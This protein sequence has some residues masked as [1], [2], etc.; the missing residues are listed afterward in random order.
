M[1]PVGWGYRKL[2]EL[3][4]SLETHLSPKGVDAM[5]SYVTIGIGFGVGLGINGLCKRFIKYISGTDPGV[6]FFPTFFGVYFLGGL[7]VVRKHTNMKTARMKKLADEVIQESHSLKIQ[8]FKKASG[9]QKM[10]SVQEKGWFDNIH[11]WSFQTTRE[12]ETGKPKTLIIEATNCLAEHLLKI[13][14]LINNRHYLENLRNLSETHDIT[15]I[16]PRTE[17]ELINDLNQIPDDSIDVLW[18]RGHGGPEVISF[19]RE[20]KPSTSDTDL[21]KNLAKKIKQL[22][23]AVFM[24][25][26]NAKGKKNITRLFSTFLKNGKT[27]GSKTNVSYCGWAW[28]DGKAEFYE[29]RTEFSEPKNVTK[30]YQNGY[31]VDSAAAAPAA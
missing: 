26:K 12:D 3:V 5:E 17:K 27:F 24:G 9:F 22:V 18:L 7:Y 6:M 30:E 29:P 8:N 14:P 2:F 28:K 31:R 15:L 19:S 16:R 13:F 23:M 11:D 4:N 21:L 20:I 10:K 1:D 25:C